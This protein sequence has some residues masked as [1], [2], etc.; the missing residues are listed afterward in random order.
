[1]GFRNEKNEKK[2]VTGLRLHARRGRELRV[3]SISEFVLG[4]GKKKGDNVN[5]QQ[6]KERLKFR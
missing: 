6:E 2:R 4:N 1:M 5:R 3:G